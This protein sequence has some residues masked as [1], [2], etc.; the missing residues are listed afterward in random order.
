[1]K[2][3]KPGSLVTRDDVTSMLGVLTSDTNVSVGVITTTSD[4]A[5]GVYSDEAL[6]KFMPHRLELRPKDKLMELLKDVAAKRPATK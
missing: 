1:M 5:P 4:F 2:A 3:Y 6:K